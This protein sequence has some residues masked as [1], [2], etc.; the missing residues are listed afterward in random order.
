MKSLIKDIN[1]SKSHVK[2]NG[3]TVIGKKYSIKF[4]GKYVFALQGLCRMNNF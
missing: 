3:I 2:T 4:T 1:A